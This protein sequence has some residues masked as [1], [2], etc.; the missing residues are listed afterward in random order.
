VRYHVAGILVTVEAGCSSQF[1]AVKNIRKNMT[2]KIIGVTEA[3]GKEEDLTLEF[4]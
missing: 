4:D 3:K 1:K 2:R